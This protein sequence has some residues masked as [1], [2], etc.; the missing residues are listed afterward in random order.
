[1]HN[2]L[3]RTFSKTEVQLL[4][5]LNVH[6]LLSIFAENQINAFVK[7][8]ANY[9]HGNSTFITGPASHP[10]ALMIVNLCEYLISLISDNVPY[11]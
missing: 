10:V 11:R 7:V 4:V 2:C 3:Q 6:Y 8:S 1:M 5:W 9:S